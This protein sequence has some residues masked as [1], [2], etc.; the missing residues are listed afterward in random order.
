LD[1]RL[2]AGG[3]EAVRL[4]ESLKPDVLVL[5]L[6]VP[7]LSGLEAL[8]ILR[9]RPPQTRIVTLSMHRSSASVAQALQNGAVGYVLNTGAGVSS[10]RQ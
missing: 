5:D 3:L 8:R 4:T 2:A 7:G 10:V 9:E 6:M 1:C